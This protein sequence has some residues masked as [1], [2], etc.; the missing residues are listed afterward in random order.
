[1]KKFVIEMKTSHPDAPKP[2]FKHEIEAIDLE[3]AQ[4]TASLLKAM[5]GKCEILYVKEVLAV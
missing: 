5:W 4:L 3:D 1:M 2:I